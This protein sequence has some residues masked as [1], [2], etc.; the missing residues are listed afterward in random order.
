MKGSK[1]SELTLT[2]LID[3]EVVNT[4]GQFFRNREICEATGAS[5]AHVSQ[6]LK[7]LYDEGIVERVEREWHLVDQGK[8]VTMLLR[9]ARS[10]ELMATKLIQMSPLV[11]SD[12]LDSIQLLKNSRNE[13]QGHA[14]RIEEEL[15][16]DIN[17]SIE[18]LRNMRS[19][20]KNP[21]KSDKQIYA[22]V[23]NSGKYASNLQATFKTA[24]PVFLG[25]EIE[26]NVVI[27]DIRAPAVARK[28]SMQKSDD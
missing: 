5:R 27:D 4:G 21:P 16:A 13:W 26:G 17:A 10:Q 23:A 18:N 1:M 7:K 14:Y 9:A 28:E 25:F 24:C 22:H 12:L 2:E 15:L 3:S 20:I 11:Q 19:R 6:R 8:L